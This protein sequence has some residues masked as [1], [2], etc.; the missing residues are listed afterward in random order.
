MSAHIKNSYSRPSHIQ[1]LSLSSLQINF[2]KPH[3]TSMI[4]LYSTEYSTPARSITAALSLQ[5][6]HCSHGGKNHSHHTAYRLTPTCLFVS[7]AIQL[8]ISLLKVFDCRLSDFESK[9]TI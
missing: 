1:L 8:I 2:I 4:M 9:V 6:F 5:L 3:G 7:A